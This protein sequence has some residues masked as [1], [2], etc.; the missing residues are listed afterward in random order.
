MS[1]RGLAQRSSLIVSKSIEAS[2]SRSPGCGDGQTPVAGL[3]FD[4][5][6]NLYG[7]TYVGGEYGYGT[8]FEVTP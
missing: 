5:E 7:T 3:I 2:S 1:G 6:G 4:K 8:V